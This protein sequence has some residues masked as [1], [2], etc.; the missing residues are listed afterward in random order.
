[1]IMCKYYSS[2]QDVGRVENIFILEGESYYYAEVKVDNTENNNYYVKEKT[3][4]MVH[5]VV[6]TVL[7]F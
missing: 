7:V 4:I 3:Y 2:V 5:V 1:M 6:Y